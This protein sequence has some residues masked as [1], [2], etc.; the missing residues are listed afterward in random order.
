MTDPL[1]SAI[2][3]AKPIRHGLDAFRESAQTLSQELNVS[4]I[5]TVLDRIGSEGKGLQDHAL[6]LVLALQALP[7]SRL[8]PSS[9][10]EKNLFGDLSRLNQ[11]I[12]IGDFDPR[13]VTPLLIAVINNESDDIIWHK[14]YDVVA[15]SIPLT[16]VAKPSTPPA[17]DPPHTASFQQTPWTFN[18]GSFADTSDLRKNVDPIL[19]SE[20]EDNLRIDHPDFFDTFFGQIPR[21]REMTTAVLRSCKDAEPPLFQ[22]DVG[23]VDWPDICEETAVL[24]FLRRHINQLLLFA[25]EHGF[26]P[27]KRRRCIATPNMPIP[28][29][30]SKRKLDVG[31][32][33][34]SSNEL[35]ESDRQS[36]DWS[37]ILIPGEL[38]S[39]PREDNYNSTWLDLVRYAREIFSAQDTRRFVLGFTLCG[40]I[41]RL[42]EFDRLGVVGST[43]FDINKD[44]EIFASII[45]GY[46]WMS[47]EELGFD[48]TIVEDDGRYTHIQ[49]DGQ[50]ERLCVEELMKR[51]RSVAGRATTCWRGS[52]M[53]ESKRGLVIKDSWEY[54][55]RHEEGL[56]L[57][58]ATEAGV[59][60]VARYYHHET[61]RT[62]GEVDDILAN[63]RKGLSNTVGRNPFQRRAAH[64]E[65]VTSPITSSALGPGRGRSKS[66]SRTIT[67]KRSSSSVQASMPPPKRSCSDSPVK[68][69]MQQRRNRVHRR[70]VMQDIGKSIYE[71]SSPRAILTGLLGG[72]RGHES[73]LDAKILHRDVSIGNVML[74]IAEDDG[75]LIDLDLA[76]KIDRE[77]ASGAPSK[78]GTKV[79]MA[80]GA[81]YGEDH[82]FMH[83]LESFFWVLF[84]SCIHCTGPGGQRR[85]SEFQA[86]NF[87]STENLA[88]IKAGSV[89]EE[90]KFSKEVD[91]NFATYC[92]P[93]IPCIKE[94]R[95][96]VFP[97]GKRWLREDRQLYSRMKAV[98]Q[99]ARKDLDSIE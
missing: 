56:L 63:V 19:K 50:V 97:E 90:D 82:N 68:Q 8:L 40:S 95:K 1:R 98:L 77:N 88:K 53:D 87:E 85:V 47:E 30:V 27:S 6:D 16:A 36:Y 92:T 35:E 70:L 13:R 84:W 7:T 78:T 72:I 24:Q 74:N 89:L 14:V 21:L 80:I 17:S 57:K 65:V 93:L 86:W 91:K 48:P 94:M 44:G 5:A 43:P 62:G 28:G 15:E 3:K 11:A 76:I 99:R 71:G 46:L 18:T 79:F 12:N 26:R 67:R 45:L 22:E 52:L 75:F 34:N 29:S 37:H 39:N 54:E 55:E 69:D 32:A 9:S 58:E 73:L 23:W 4:S 10:G 64:S 31:L 20:V 96:V 25:D 2:I 83:D 38:K 49:R 33:Y 81:L 59:K 66:R 61:V 42:W 60:N 41:M 51:Q